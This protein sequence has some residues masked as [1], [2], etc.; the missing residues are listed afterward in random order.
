[1]AMRM[2][3]KAVLVSSVYYGWNI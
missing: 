2:I 3:A 1:M